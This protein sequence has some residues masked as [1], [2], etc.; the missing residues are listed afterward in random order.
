MRPVVIV[1]LDPTRDAG[2]GFFQAAVLCCPDF[3]FLQAAM[4]PFDVAVTFRVMI[5]RA[6]MGDAEPPKRFQETRGSELRAIV[7]REGDVRLTAALGQPCQD[8]LLHGSQRIFGAATV[9]E[10]P[11]HDLP[12]AAVDHAHQ[13]RP[14]HRWPR[15]D[16]GHVRLPDLIR[17]GCFHASPFFL[18]SCAQPN[19]KTATNFEEFLDAHKKT[20]AFSL[21]DRYDFQARLFVAPP[22]ENPP[23]WLAPLRTAFGALANIP[24]SISNSAILLI[25]VKARGR[26]LH[27]AATFGFG[28]FLLRAGTIERNY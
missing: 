28:R 25:A 21:K 19:A 6:P 27:F 9:R 16:L 5:S 2:S 7:G 22:G 13:V 1:L 17:L 26:D 15:P 18:P 12:R 11:A 24:D 4:E 23:R 14:A 3:L 10:I 8:G 20:T